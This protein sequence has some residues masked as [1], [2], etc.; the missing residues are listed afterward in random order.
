MLTG[1]CG[2]ARGVERLGAGLA[3]LIWIVAQ[4]GF[5][6]IRGDVGAPDLV[7]SVDVD[8]SQQIGIDL[9]PGVWAACIGARRHTHQSHLAHEALHAFTVHDVPGSGKYYHHASAA[10]KRVPR[11]LLVYQGAQQQILSV[12]QLWFLVRVQRG[13]RNASEFTLVGGV[14]LVLSSPRSALPI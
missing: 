6:T 10:V 8:T 7:W 13:T 3:A 5:L 11:V 1:R 9:V 4:M 12:N 2:C 14:R